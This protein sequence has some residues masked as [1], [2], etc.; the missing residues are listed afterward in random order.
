MKEKESL[1]IR[2]LKFIGLIVEKPINESEKREMCKKAQSICNHRCG[3]C[4]W[5]GGSEE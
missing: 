1:L 2:F 3:S 4:I 5:G